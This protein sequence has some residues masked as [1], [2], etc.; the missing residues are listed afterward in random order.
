MSSS[1]ETEIPSQNEY[2]EKMKQLS[3]LPKEQF[4]G[5][6]T[7]AK[8]MSGSEGV[9]AQNA[10]NPEEQKV[11]EQKVPEQKVQKEQSASSSSTSLSPFN[12][13]FKYSVDAIEP[14]VRSETERLVAEAQYEED[15]MRVE[16]DWEIVAA[17]SEEAAVQAKVAGYGE[18]LIESEL[19]HNKNNQAIVFRQKA[20]KNQDKGG[21]AIENDTV[22]QFDYG[23]YKGTAMR[24]NHGV[25][26]PDKYGYEERYWKFPD[27]FGYCYN[28]WYLAQH[29]PESLKHT[30]PEGL[31]KVWTDSAFLDYATRMTAEMDRDVLRNPE[32]TWTEPRSITPILED[33]IGDIR[34]GFRPYLKYVKENGLERPFP[35]YTYDNF[36]DHPVHTYQVRTRCQAEYNSRMSS[37]NQC[38]QAIEQAH[39]EVRTAVQTINSLEK[40]KLFAREKIA[41]LFEKIQKLEVKLNKYATEKEEAEI[42]MKDC[43][44]SIVSLSEEETTKTAEQKVA[45]ENDDLF[46]PI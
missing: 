27:T 34:R 28:T 3:S 29:F 31:S 24:V 46:S 13:E 41:T 21:I 11:P 5:M 1:D 23:V 32:L 37:I 2:D 42:L 43:D 9:D 36:N 22:L 45:D 40:P 38:L 17:A 35:A 39:L 26:F 44:E 12:L 30:S 8:M 15:A 4:D 18:T 10:G 20:M 33:A 6:L 19:D 16:R 7:M 14:E 25:K